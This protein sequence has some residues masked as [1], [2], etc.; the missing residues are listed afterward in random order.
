MLNDVAPVASRTDHAMNGR[1]CVILE[2]RKD[3]DDDD[4]D[5]D[6]NDVDG[7]FKKAGLGGRV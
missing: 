5:D 7:G 1:T 4:D 2:S 6:V 3:I